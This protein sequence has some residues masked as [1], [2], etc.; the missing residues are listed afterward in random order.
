MPRDHA[1]LIQGFPQSDLGVI[2]VGWGPQPES[3]LLNS[4]DM[5]PPFL[6]GDTELSGMSSGSQNY[7]LCPIFMGVTQKQLLL[8]RNEE[9][10]DV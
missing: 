4:P 9:V 2:M 10:R 8:G 1:I 3:L 6:D 5:S 7:S